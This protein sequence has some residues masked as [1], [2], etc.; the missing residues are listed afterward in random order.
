MGGACGTYG[1]EERRVW[2]F[3]GKSEGNYQLEDTDVDGRI[4]LRR[5]F[6]KWDLG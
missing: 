2:G 4:I 3:E 1:V 5:M 6:R